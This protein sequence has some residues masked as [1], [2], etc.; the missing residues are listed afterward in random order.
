MSLYD[1]RPRAS[2]R[3]RRRTR[4]RR[5]STSSLR[6]FT[7]KTTTIRLV[8]GGEEGLGEDVTYDGAEQDA[9]QAR[10]PVLPLAGDWTIDTFS[11]H[12]DDAAPLR[13]GA[14]AARVRRLPALGVRERGARPR[15]AAGRSLARGRRRP[16][17]SARDVRRIGWA[18]RPAVDDAP[19]RLSRRSTPRSASS[20]THG[21]TG[22]TTIFAELQEL[23]CV[24]SIDLK[25]QYTGTVVDNPP[26]PELY[27]RGDRAASPRRGS[28]TPRSRRRPRR[29]SSRTPTASRG[30]RRSTRSTTSRRFAGRRRPST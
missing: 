25:G 22:G 14:G 9:Q 1:A 8:G 20:S 30:T 27:R 7:R 21:R 18:R 16:R 19:P 24:D 29:C 17:A 23:G 2:A 5:A 26:D 13:R 6:E 12:L 11:R 3:R 15:A 4:W 10:G 28:K